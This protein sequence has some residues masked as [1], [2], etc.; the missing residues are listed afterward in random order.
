MNINEDFDKIRAAMFGTRPSK[1]FKETNIISQTKGEKMDELKFN[2]TGEVLAH[3]DNGIIKLTP[4]GECLHN[5]II[6][7]IIIPLAPVTKKNSQE[8][9]V[10]KRTGKRYVAPSDN[11]TI[12]QNKCF[13]FLYQLRSHA[14]KL[15]YP[16][17]VKC[18][19][20]MP[21]RYRVDLTNLLEAID[22]VLTHYKIIID[23]SY[24]YI[25]GHDGSRVLYD[26]DNPRTE[27]YILPLDVSKYPETEDEPNCICD[28]C[29]NCDNCM[30]RHC[31]E[32]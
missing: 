16:L 19:F 15:N 14:E 29:P 26:K 1:V 4:A 23:D 22:D 8:I 28:H 10:N 25:G 21:K 18:L 32:V 5:N 27:I 24:K 9:R 2:H 3:V 12:Y 17:N 11:F 13:P 6:N 31:S 7:K 20:Y 30:R